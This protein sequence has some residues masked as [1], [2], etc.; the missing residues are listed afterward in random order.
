MAVRIF[1]SGQHQQLFDKQGFIVLPFLNSAEV[2]KLNNVFD[3]LHTDVNTSGFFSGSYS[4]D[5]NY[6]KRASD[7]IVKNFTRAY[8]ELFVDYTPFGGAFLFKVP[9]A[10]SELAAHQDWTIVDEHKHVAL[11]CW[12]PLSDISLEN[13]PLMILPGSHFT[14]LNVLRAPTLPFF[15]SGEEKMIIDELEPMI[16]KAGTAVILNQSVIHYSLPN[17]GNS[18]RKA[19]TAGVKSKGAQMYFYY[20]N[21]QEDKNE[22]EVFEEDDDFL[23]RFDNF[24]EDISKRPKNGTS[25][26]FIPYTLPQLKGKELFDK[27]TEMK[28]SAGFKMKT[29]YQVS[30]QVQNKS[31]FKKLVSIFSN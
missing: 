19:I 10:N 31:L 12:V 8:E 17:L 25:I 6:K 26:G 2:D 21:L 29:Q 5:F 27:I 18:V 14:N 1:K 15:F 3:E 11:N 7:E 23:I 30:E 28:I 20:K 16:V 24:V 22:L 13:G 4:P 9:G